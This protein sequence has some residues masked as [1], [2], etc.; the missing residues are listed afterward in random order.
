MSQGI[1][2]SVQKI[3]E[4]L[5]TGSNTTIA[6]HLKSW[7]EEY[8]KKTIHYLPP[9]MPKELISTLEVLWQEAMAQAENQFTEYK[10]TVETECKLAQQREMDAEKSVADIKQELADL[11]NTL[12]QETTHKQKLTIEL[13]IIN[14][15]LTKQDEALVVQKNLY[16]DRLKRAY[17]EKESAITQ[18][19][20]LKHDIKIIQEKQVL[21][22]EQ[23]QHSLAQQNNLHEQSEIRWLNLVDQTKQETKEVHKKLENTCKSYDEKIIQLKSTLADLQKSAYENS[24]RLTVSL[25]QINQL[26]QEN[27][28]LDAEKMKAMTAVIKLEEVYKNT[29]TLAQNKSKKEKHIKT[30][31]GV[32]S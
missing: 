26:K 19:Q 18:C 10:L 12:E 9:T 25:E 15:R 17:E 7:R 21:Q 32:L 23:H 27:K 5:G 24:A 31:I 1:A 14:E 16:E 3:R 2:P 22:T 11:S 20:Q 13:A 29:Y 8:T 28:M 30:K 6:E 4:V